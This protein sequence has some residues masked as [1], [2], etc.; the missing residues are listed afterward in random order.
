MI[1][2]MGSA[3]GGFVLVL[4]ASTCFGT[5]GIFSSLAYDEGADPW[6]LLF[7]RFAIT[8]P[9]LV[10]LALALRE[11][12]PGR[13]GVVLGL[14]LGILQI[15]VGVGLLEGF[16]RAPVALVTLLY[17]AY[18]LI[19]SVGAALV[20]RERISPQRGVIL[21]VA[22]TGVVL[23]VGLPDSANVAGVILGLLAGLCVSG[24]ILS[25]QYV[26]AKESVSPVV[27]CA[28]MFSSPVLV[29]LLLLPWRAP[30]FGM[31]G[32]AWGWALC[33]VLIA[34]TIPIGCFYAGVRRVGAAVAGLLSTAEPV[35][36]VSVPQV[37]GN[38]IYVIGQV[39]KPGMFVMNPR[40]NVVQALSLAA[41]TTPFAKLDDIIVIRSTG[42][43]QKAMPFRY[44]QITSGKDLS[45]NVMLESGDV[46]LVP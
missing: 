38:R 45:Q 28:L 12:W 13:R 10:L 30:N 39:N 4:L 14:L 34:A 37:D 16:E 17:F 22:L 31:S 41:G 44:S 32:P 2:P 9:L 26:M 43:T 20:Y 7:L 18:P 23:V 24:L 27:L 1:P 5:L 11:P 25:S 46:V 19:T 42:G 21:A 35:V 40:V 15:G 8:S 3:R 6:T 36:T 29:L 33:G